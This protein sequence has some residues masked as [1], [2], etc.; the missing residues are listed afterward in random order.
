L[1]ITRLR[2]RGVWGCFVAQLR[3]RMTTQR[4]LSEELNAI[5][6]ETEKDTL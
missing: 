3:W 1:R 4:S 2:P 6:L 5:A